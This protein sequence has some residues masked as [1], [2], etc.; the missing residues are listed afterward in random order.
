MSLRKTLHNIGTYGPVDVSITTTGTPPTPP[1]ACT[2][3]ADPANPTS[4]T[5]PVSVDEVVDEV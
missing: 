3:T 2:V 1:P 5:L 4:A